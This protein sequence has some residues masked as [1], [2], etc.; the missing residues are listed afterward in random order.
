MKKATS[1][2]KQKLI[3]KIKKVVDSLRACNDA[4]CVQSAHDG[5]IKG[6]TAKDQDVLGG[7]FDNLKNS[8][9]CISKSKIDKIQNDANIQVNIENIKNLVSALSK[10]NGNKSCINNIKGKINKIQ[11]E[12]KKLGSQSKIL[13]K[14][15]I[16]C[17]NDIKN[18]TEKVFKVKK[19][20]NKFIKS[21]KKSWKKLKKRIRKLKKQ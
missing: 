8:L 17:A 13:T 2:D 14:K 12:S 5:F 1:K 15:I 16:N 6:L 10:C 7:S 21:H 20:I 11:Q 3:D 4:K 19:F 18:I 9:E